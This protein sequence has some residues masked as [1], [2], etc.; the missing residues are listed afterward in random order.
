MKI[1]VDL[2]T[3]AI[4]I[5][6]E[7]EMNFQQVI[8]DL[9]TLHLGAMSETLQR[10]LASGSSR[11]LSHEEFVALLVADE[12]SSRRNRKL[13]RLIAHA[14]FKPEQATLENVIYTPDRGITRKDISSFYTSSWIDNNQNV[15]VSGPTGSGKTYLAES[16]G[17]QACIQGH[18]V[19]KIRYP[20]LFE[21]ISNSRGTGEYLKY[22][23]R[24]SKTRIIILD[25]FL[26]QLISVAD[27]GSLLE[28]INEKEQTG[29]LIVTTQLPIE[30][31][32]GKL[33][34]PSIADAICDR[35]VHRAIRLNMSGE[36]MRRNPK[37]KKES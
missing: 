7:N 5:T 37:V 23:K 8:D 13:S 22:L 6:K 15:I 30:K 11:E 12:V 31:W 27:S 1:F 14:D 32:H 36:S 29:S 2:S 9:K 25:D 16:I 18:S 26:M 10:L 4:T 35:L 20:M 33:P 19:I 28:I 34:D 3:I 21:E 24:L 17:Y